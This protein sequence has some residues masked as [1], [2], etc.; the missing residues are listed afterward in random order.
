MRHAIIERCTERDGQSISKFRAV[1]FPR[2]RKYGPKKVYC[3]C[4]DEIGSVL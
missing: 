2:L 3:L 4:I 1:K